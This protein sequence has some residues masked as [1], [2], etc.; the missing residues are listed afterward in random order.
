MEVKDTGSECII[1]WKEYKCADRHQK[2]CCERHADM[3]WGSQRAS[4]L[5]I[6]NCVLK[7]WLTWLSAIILHYTNIALNSSIFSAHLFINTRWRH[8]SLSALAHSF[9][10]S[11]TVV[12]LQRS[13]PPLCLQ[14]YHMLQMQNKQAC[15]FVFEAQ[16]TNLQLTHLHLKQHK[17]RKEL[18]LE[19]NIY[20]TPTREL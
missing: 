13:S 11:F 3:V 19:N 7:I 20:T 15:H 9:I 1:T 18:E 14:W 12:L 17:A 16:H 6:I 2:S 10:H 4:I 5:R 8:M